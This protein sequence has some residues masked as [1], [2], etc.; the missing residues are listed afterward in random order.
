MSTINVP[1]RALGTDDYA[2][3]MARAAESTVALAQDLKGLSAQ[4]ASVIRG[5]KDL[6]GALGIAAALRGFAGYAV[7]AAKALGS[8]AQNAADLVDELHTAAGATGLSVESVQALKLA[9][10][11]SGKSLSDMLPKELA[12]KLGELRK[13]T[14]EVK[15]AFDS[16][17]LSSKDFIGLD[18]DQSYQKIIRA[19][20]DTEDATVRAAAAM[21]ILGEGG[22]QALSAFGDVSEFDAY[23]DRAATM[24]TT[25]DDAA[26]ATA[27][28]QRVYGEMA[29]IVD[30]V[31]AALLV[32]ADNA[33]LFDGALLALKT[34]GLPVIQGTYTATL[35]LSRAWQQILDLS[36]SPLNPEAI[37]QLQAALEDARRDSE[38]FFAGLSS[39]LDTLDGGEQTE[40]TRI[41]IVAKAAAAAREEIDRLSPALAAF[42]RALERERDAQ[43]EGID[44]IEAKYSRLRRGY[45][46]EA[47]AIMAIAD[48]TADQYATLEDQFTD[49]LALAQRAYDAEVAAFIA[50]EE[51]KAAAENERLDALRAREA[52]D[53]KAREARDAEAALRQRQVQ[54]ETN[55]AI[56]DSSSN[57]ARGLVALGNQREAANA[58]QARRRWEVEQGINLAIAAGQAAIGLSRAAASAPPPA[59]IPAI[60][61]ATI[62][63][64]ANVLAVRAV[65]APSFH[66]GSR[67]GDLAPD[68][69]R[70]TLTRREVVLTPQ[71]QEAA[72]LNAGIRST[73]EAPVLILGH[74]V[75]G[76]M[77]AAEMRRVGSDL[78]A[79]A[80]RG[81]LPGHSRT[82]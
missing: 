55:A 49:R 45:E 12:V 52:A 24:I 42:Q 39:G 43:R 38:L 26:E 37:R 25:S 19:L 33:G 75:V 30:E 47:A 32:A 48:L 68:E 9:A 8:M 44:A 65:P 78:Y 59:N 36:R 56:F 46:E 16:I 72:N 51:A 61:A 2:R 62:Q 54:I 13:G 20:Y 70:A 31:G 28:L 11:R 73:S 82:R 81:D 15:A 80:R 40:P 4:Q 22:K 76:E 21:K 67:A 74:R 41:E 71:G 27:K 29:E 3:Q 17:G 14:G 50:A 7:D 53:R 6:V 60:I 35:L 57:L 63:G 10:D 34:S 5:A 66:I 79:A 64:A 23:L 69:M 58:A 18:A 1:I 77:V